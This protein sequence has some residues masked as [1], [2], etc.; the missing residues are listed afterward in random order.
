[1]IQHVQGIHHVTAIASDPQRNVDFYAGV[2]GLRLVKQTVNFDDPGSYHLYYGDEAGQPGTI[3]TFFPWPGARRGRGG[4]GQAS[5]T[6]FAVPAGALRAW[7]ARL[8]SHGVVVG[9]PTERFGETVLTFS[10]PDGLPLELIGQAAPGAAP[11]GSALAADQAIRGFHSV[12]LAVR[13]HTATGAALAALGF[14]LSAT[15]GQRQRWTLGTGALASTVDVLALPTTDRGTVAAGSVHH[16]AWR[17][18]DDAAQAAWRTALLAAGYGVSP[19]M[20]RQ[21]F[22]SI[23]FREPGGILFEIAT[24]PPGFATDELPAELGTRLQLPPWMEPQR[25]Q[26]TQLLPP[27]ALPTG[28]ASV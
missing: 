19:V 7:R 8:Q 4:T 20:D 2:L 12:T 13:D 10:D 24:D 1:M 11:A 22:H 14:A 16:I 25:A 5:A 26:I 23:Y 27:L 17:T 21:Y 3:M 28:A 6:A 15:A 18:P 9:E